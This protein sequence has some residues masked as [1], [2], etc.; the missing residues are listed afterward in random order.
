MSLNGEEPQALISPHDAATECAN[1]YA[2][3]D[4]WQRKQFARRLRDLGADQTMTVST[5]TSGREP[6]VNP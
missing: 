5:A 3:F 4:D 2:A 1:L 6:I